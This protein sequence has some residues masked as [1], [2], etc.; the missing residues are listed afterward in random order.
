MNTDGEI[1]QQQAKALEK[2]LRKV[3]SCYLEILGWVSLLTMLGDL[4]IRRKDVKIVGIMMNA[5]EF[6]ERKGMR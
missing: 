6:L 2:E 1:L 4:A 5:V 3:L